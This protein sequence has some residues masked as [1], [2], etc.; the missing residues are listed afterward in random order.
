MIRV[1]AQE[2]IT[3]RRRHLWLEAIALVKEIKGEEAKALLVEAYHL[4]QRGV[5]TSIEE[6]LSWLVS[7]EGDRF[8]FAQSLK[9]FQPA[10]SEA[11]ITE[12]YDRATANQLNIFRD[13]Q[14]QAYNPDDAL[15]AL[16]AAVILDDNMDSI[17]EDFQDH[18]RTLIKVAQRSI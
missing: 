6:S 13:F 2:E 8:H 17:P 14:Y 9:K 18:V 7:P 12:I 3:K 15:S 4:Q 1:F 11:Q 10:L 5:V 16:N